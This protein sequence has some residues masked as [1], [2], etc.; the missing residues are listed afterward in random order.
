MSDP[1]KFLMKKPPAPEVEET[2][3]VRMPETQADGTHASPKQKPTAKKKRGR[4]AIGEARMTN[5]EYA[6]RYR[7]KQKAARAYDDGS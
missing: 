4:P 2:Q 1:F 6:R 3:A 5:A 7:E